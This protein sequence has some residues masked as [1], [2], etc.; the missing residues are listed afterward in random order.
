MSRTSLAAVFHGPE[1]PLTFEQFE[2]P[3]LQAGE[4][5]V[6]I[7]CA[8]L[9]GS[10]LHTFLGHRQA[11][12]PSVL[13][14]EIVGVVAEVNRESPAV[15]VDGQMLR[16]GNRVTW[17]IAANC[18]SCFYCTHEVP[19]KCDQLFKYGH[20]P[21][22][23]QHPLSGGLAEYCHL[24]AGTAVLQVPDTLSDRIVCPANCATATAAAAVRNA[25]NCQ[26]SS[27]LIQGAGMLGLTAAAMARE[28][29]ARQVIVCDV[30]PQRLERALDF[31]A[32]HTLLANDSDS[33]LQEVHG[34]TSG[35]GVD[36]AIEMSG[37]PRAAATGISLLRIGG[38][39]VLIGNVSPTPA[40]EVDPES[41][42]RRCL[43]IV[44]SHNYRPGDLATAVHFLAACANRYPFEELVQG[45][46]TL[47]EADAAFARARTG[48]DFRIAVWPG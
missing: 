35:R 39:Y 45:E 8:T 34:L 21:V 26:G 46:F 22:V 5:L 14:H 25:G 29:G 43:T 19:Q 6:R 7:T 28:Q 27:L 23:P 31:G 48:Q 11:P 30:E 13:G 47:A 3:S 42:V 12:T 44:G 40:V 33:L 15:D 2:L 41:L 37:A 9:C 18:G 32:T 17:S 16:P 36:L 20:E 24:A 1:Q 38:R 10:D 4:L